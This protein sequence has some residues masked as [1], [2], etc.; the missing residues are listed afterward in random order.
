MRRPVS[1]GC[2][3][4]PTFTAPFLLLCSIPA[5]IIFFILFS[6]VNGIVE[7][8]AVCGGLVGTPVEGLALLFAYVP[9]KFA[10]EGSALGAFGPGKLQALPCISA[11]L[12][13][14]GLL[15]LSVFYGLDEL[16]SGFLLRFQRLKKRG[17][18]TPC[19]PFWWPPL[20]GNPR[21]IIFDTV[22]GEWYDGR[23]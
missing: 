14:A 21:L 8:I 1:A 3:T 12:Q 20:T 2:D 16:A 23:Q 6:R 10:V 4:L 18:G 9:L 13:H 15:I 17:N 7:A 11:H 5:E 22:N 19:P